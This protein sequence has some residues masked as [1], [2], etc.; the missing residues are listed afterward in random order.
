MRQAA[1]E[2]HGLSSSAAAAESA[3]SA[4]ASAAA[5]V[6][7]A[8]LWRTE[9]QSDPEFQAAQDLEWRQRQAVI[10]KQAEEAQRLKRQRRAVKEKKA[11]QEVCWPNLCELRTP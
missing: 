5:A 7:V 10:E 2:T 4:E 6:G 11:R 8:E 9:Q 1:G 3:Q